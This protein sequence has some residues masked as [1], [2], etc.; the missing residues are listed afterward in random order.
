M[1]GSEKRCEFDFKK[2]GVACLEAEFSD[3]AV[4]CTLEWFTTSKLLRRV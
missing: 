3:N 2:G 4:R 1:T